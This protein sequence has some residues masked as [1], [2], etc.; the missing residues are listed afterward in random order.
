MILWTE[1]AWGPR[2]FTK[3]WRNDR[4]M[5]VLLSTRNQHSIAELQLRSGFC[6]RGEQWAGRFATRSASEDPHLRH[7]RALGSTAAQRH[8]RL[9]ASN[10]RDT[11]DLESSEACRCRLSWTSTCTPAHRANG[12]KRSARLDVT[13][14]YGIGA[15]AAYRL[16]KRTTALFL[17]DYPP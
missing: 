16:I 1:I 2:E 8:A 5:P 9:Y 12:R 11:N 7:V 3:L 17:R 10:L 15:K 14:A 4:T 13:A 6:P